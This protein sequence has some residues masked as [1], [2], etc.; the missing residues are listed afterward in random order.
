MKMTRTFERFDDI[1]RFLVGHVNKSRGNIFWGSG[2]A[3]MGVW[4]SGENGQDTNSSN[5]A[6]MYFRQG[7]IF[8]T[9]FV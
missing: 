8:K 9:L 4:L 7:Q 3:C 5:F 6:L 1:R 2:G